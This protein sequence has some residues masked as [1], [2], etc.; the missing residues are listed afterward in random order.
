MKW[1]N[2]NDAEVLERARAAIRESWRETCELNKGLPGF[3]PDQLPAFHAPFAGGGALPLEAQRLGLESWASDLNPVAVMLNKAMI[4][5]PPRFAARPPVGP[6]PAGERPL[7]EQDWRGAAGLAEDVR[8]YGHWMREEAFR[9]IG[10][11]YPQVAITPEMVAERPDLKPYKGKKLTVIAWLWAR[12][13]PSPHPDF[14]GAEVPLVSTFV[15]SKKA[16]KEAW[17][18]PVVEGKS[19]RFEVRV[20]KP[21]KEAEKGTKASAGNFSCLLSNAVIENRYIREQACAGQMHSRLMAV[22]LEGNVNG[23]MLTLRLNKKRL[24]NPPNRRGSPT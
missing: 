23:F 22:V 14:R 12:T 19:Y 16:G 8:R 24:H 10:H 21:P 9:R 3:D 17:V 5:I 18:Q 11:L 6:L 15:L 7:L 20:G 4:E 2:T 1:E 13:V